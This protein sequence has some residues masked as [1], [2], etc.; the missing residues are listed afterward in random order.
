[1][2]LDMFL[3]MSRLVKRRTQAQEMIQAGAVTLN[4]QRSKPAKEVRPGDRVSVT[5]P[6][7][8]VTVKVVDVPVRG[9]RKAEAGDC[10]ELL[11]E[12]GLE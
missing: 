1:M 3:K 4:G 11:E 8:S 6:R 7:R 12:I 5:Y 10:Y 2:R 9:T